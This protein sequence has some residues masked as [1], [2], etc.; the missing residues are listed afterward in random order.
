SG[1]NNELWGVAS[2]SSNDVWAVGSAGNQTLVEHYT[3]NCPPATNTPAPTNTSIPPTNTPL[4]TNT[5]IC[6]AGW[7]IVNSPNVGS[8]ANALKRVAAVSATDVWAVGQYR[9]AS[10]GSDHTLI[11]HW[12]GSQWSVVSS[13]N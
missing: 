8:G 4:P 2:V 9:D 5:P 6:V 3:A 7:N 12:N 10:T 11:E 1:Q 13:P